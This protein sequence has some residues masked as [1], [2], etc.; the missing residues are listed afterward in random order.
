MSDSPTPA[1]EQPRTA[2][3]AQLV[4]AG[5]AAVTKVGGMTPQQI[6][7]VGLI[8]VLF[9]IITAFGFQIWSEKEE[10]AAE[11][12][13]RQDAEAGRMREANAQ[14]E[15]LRNHCAMENDRAR[16]EA[17]ENVSRIL[18][19]FITEGEKSRVHQ[20]AENEKFRREVLGALRHPANG[21]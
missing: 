6:V 9:A 15:L 13:E 1:P 8:M 7:H 2:I 5:A 14:S 12:R 17:N 16:K 21:P 4:D 11:R 10:R 20:S 3:H 19:T 18:A